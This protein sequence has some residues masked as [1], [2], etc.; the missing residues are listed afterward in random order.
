MKSLV[1][2]VG[3]RRKKQQM[4]IEHYNMYALSKGNWDL[5]KTQR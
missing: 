4:F 2:C 5:E 3:N 1:L